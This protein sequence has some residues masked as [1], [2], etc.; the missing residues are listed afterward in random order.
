M[1]SSSFAG[2]GLGIGLAC[3]RRI[4]LRA[5]LLRSSCDAFAAWHWRVRVL[6][7]PRSRAGCHA[8]VWRPARLGC[9]VLVSILGCA[10]LWV[11]WNSI[12]HAHGCLGGAALVGLGSEL[13]EVS[14]FTG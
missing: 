9:A 5:E 7:V 3:G 10:R 4:T 14:L 8:L 2:L 13:R 6:H 12:S 1:Q 11:L